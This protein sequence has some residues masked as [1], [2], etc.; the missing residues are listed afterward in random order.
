MIKE[1]VF[2]VSVPVEH[3]SSFFNAIVDMGI[4]AE[5]VVGD[6]VAKPRKS[7]KPVVDAAIFARL[8]AGEELGYSEPVMRRVRDAAS[9][10]AY[11]SLVRESKETPARDDPQPEAERVASTENDRV[12]PKIIQ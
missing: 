6:E 4:S 8:K 10:E 5:Q 2:R 1:M 12:G 11:Q 9:Y 3:V 7:R